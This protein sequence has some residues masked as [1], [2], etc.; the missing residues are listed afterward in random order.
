MTTPPPTINGSW[1]IRHGAGETDEA[2]EIVVGDLGFVVVSAFGGERIPSDGFGAG[3][4][5]LFSGLLLTLSGWTVSR[6]G[7]IEEISKT[8]S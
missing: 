7:L 3:R 4:L 8:V 6:F 5:L 2:G 1:D